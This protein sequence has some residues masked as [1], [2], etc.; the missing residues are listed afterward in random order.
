MLNHTERVSAA[1]AAVDYITGRTVEEQQSPVP[2]CPGWTVYNA[3]AHV[4]RVG[5]AWE[6]MITSLPDDPE[7]RARGYAESERRPAGAS[8]SGLADW[9]HAALAHLDLSGHELD[10]PC[11]FSMTGGEGTVGLW[12]WHAAS[13]LGVHRLDVEMALGHPHS[14]SSAAALD[15]ATYTCQ[16]FL[17]AMRR[18]TERD[19]GGITARLVED[20]DV[21][22]I[23]TIESDAPQSATLEGPP[24]QVLLA[25]WGR[26]HHGVDVVDGD[27]QVWDGW[28]AL[29]GEAFQFG[30]WD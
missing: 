6:E 28:Q 4:G 18:V 25:L 29:P 13:E 30:T 2:N 12:A 1:K 14:L 21:V 23:A 9:A 8:M 20:G 5:I 11:Y 7:S 3:A 27:R 16:Y 22:G 19:P 15:A 10:R 26:P 24:T 17:P